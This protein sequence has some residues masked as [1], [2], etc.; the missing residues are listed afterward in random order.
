MFLL[1]F[2]ELNSLLEKSKKEAAAKKQLLYMGIDFAKDPMEQIINH[3]KNF[4]RIHYKKFTAWMRDADV[5][6]IVKKCNKHEI[7]M[8]IAKQLIEAYIN[9]HFDPTAPP[10]DP[11][12]RQAELSRTFKLIS[13]LDKEE[14]KRINDDIYLIFTAAAYGHQALVAKLLEAGAACHE[15]MHNPRNDI[16]ELPIIAAAREG[17]KEIVTLLLPHTPLTALDL[18]AL[19]QQG[20]NPE[21][22]KLL[23][24]AIK[25][26]EPVLP[27]F[28]RQ[29]SFSTITPKE[30]VS[31]TPEHRDQKPKA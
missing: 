8:D 5:D 23:S 25:T 2:D 1:K 9:K 18:V 14:Q 12:K 7:P 19:K 15:K 29:K 13:L 20:C 30:N 27:M 10:V 24:T 6:D 17:Y 11:E 16:E 31:L 3:S 26:E 28:E 21:I 4:A 22:L